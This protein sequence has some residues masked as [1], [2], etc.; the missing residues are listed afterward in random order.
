MFRSIQCIFFLIS[1][2][3]YLLSQVN[4]RPN[5][6]LIVTDDQ[7]WDAIGCSGNKIIHT[8][9]MDKLASESSYYKNAFVTTPICAA[10]RASIITGLYERTHDYTFGTP[11]LSSSYI[12]MS[13]PKL[14]RDNGYE[15]GFFGKL[16]INMED[17]IDTSLFNII[18]TARTAGYFRLQGQSGQEH[19]HLTDLTTNKAI[20]FIDQRDRSKPF[21]LS[22]SY[23]APHADDQS[24]QQ[25]FWPERN[26]HLYQDITIP[27]PNLGQNKDLA[28]LPDF[29]SDSTTISRLRW[30]W[31]YNS[32][33]KYQRMVK[34]YYRMIST[35]DDNLGR[36]RNKLE[37]QGIG[38]NTIIILIGDNGYF[39]GERQLA[40]KWL[41]YDN[42]LRVPLIIY[43]PRVAGTVKNEMALNID[44]APTIIDYAGI[45]IPDLI[46]GI[47]LNARTT[48]KGQAI[49]TQFHCE[50]HFNNKYIP[51]SEGLRTDQYKYFRY[52]DYPEVEEL[53]D[54]KKDPLETINLARDLKYRY[55]LNL[56]RQQTD[57]KIKV[58]TKASLD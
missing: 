57:D 4:Q 8:P 13:Y 24:V 51:K 10:S 34:G 20:E 38:D 37:G 21:C 49:R 44:I 52:I 11:P 31:R 54:L 58:L 48:K 26:D 47:S 1:I 41:M 46:Q 19:I 29:V 27:D 3:S 35:I 18:W 12:D 6:V 16:G 14:L 56:M 5:I 25:Y 39:L 42:S 40:G 22:I 15:T 28:A 32:P 45:P 2:S 17:G 50:H 55:R 23:N 33:E 9:V 53:Y 30:H 43:D 36:L 7:R